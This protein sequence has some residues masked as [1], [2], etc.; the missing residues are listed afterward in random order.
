MTITFFI[1]LIAVFAFFLICYIGSGRIFDRVEGI[2][3]TKLDRK[4]Q[5]FLQKVDRYYH[6]L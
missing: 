3:Q 2:T 5:R 6:E 4:H 1:E